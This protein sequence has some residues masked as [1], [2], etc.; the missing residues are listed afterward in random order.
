[1][2]LKRHTW[3]SGAVW[4]LG[5]VIV[6][7]A[8]S[9]V[10]GGNS[11]AVAADC[12]YPD[13]YGCP[14]AVTSL[15]TAADPTS[16]EAGDTLSAQSTLS[17]GDDPTGTLTFRLFAAND[18]ACTSEVYR[19]DVAVTGNGAYLAT[20]G[21]QTGSAVATMPG[22]WRWAVAYSG[23]DAN[24]P[25]TSGCAEDP[26]TVTKATTS[27]TAVAT[28][29]VAERRD[30]LSVTATLEG[31][32]LPGGAVTFTLY[33]PSKHDPPCTVVAATG[34]VNVS[35]GQASFGV[36]LP[37]NARLGSWEWV[38]EYAG[39]A[40]NLGSESTCGEAT[41]VVVAHLKTP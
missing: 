31:G 12:P 9:L 22:T 8:A 39:D 5:A 6:V 29:D 14:K 40:N 24:E 33:R 35:Q 36:T 34:T 17:N 13:P 3:R 2:G 27:L 10:V 28:P 26:V 21:T 19:S 15:T 38:A 16:A 18:A 20:S 30:A 41:T 32:Y 23:D 1:M 25:S 4:A 11:V 37:R 7:A